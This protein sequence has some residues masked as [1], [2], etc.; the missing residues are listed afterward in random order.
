MPRNPDVNAASI[1]KWAGISSATLPLQRVACR[2]SAVFTFLEGGLMVVRSGGS[3]STINFDPIL[4]GHLELDGS[5]IDF[6]KTVLIGFASPVN[7]T[8]DLSDLAFNANTKATFA[9]RHTTG[10]VTVTNGSQ[11]AKLTLFV[12]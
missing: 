5:Q 3:A 12:Q 1:L 9:P 4:G 2:P 7:D 6:T 10:T 8:I 11:T